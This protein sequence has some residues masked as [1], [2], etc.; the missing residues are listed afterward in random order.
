M[1]WCIS[2]QET[3]EVVQLLFKAIKERSPDVEIH[4][5]MTDDGKQQYL[6]LTM[7]AAFKMTFGTMEE[8]QC[9]EV[10]YAIYYATGM[11]IGMYMHSTLLQMYTCK[12]MLIHMDKGWSIV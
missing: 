1:A 12:S 2:S 4:T 9:L 6:Y 5:L 11:L 3:T 10:R 7:I 8:K